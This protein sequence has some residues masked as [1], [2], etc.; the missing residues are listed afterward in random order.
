MNLADIPVLYETAND[1]HALPADRETAAQYLS[2]N[3]DSILSAY[4][5][6]HAFI[7][8]YELLLGRNSMDRIPTGKYVDGWIQFDESSVPDPEDRVHN[9]VFALARDA[10]MLADKKKLA[11]V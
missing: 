7:H 11:A 4:L 2:E 10:R 5:A 9:V 1:P 3:A 6:Q 8:D